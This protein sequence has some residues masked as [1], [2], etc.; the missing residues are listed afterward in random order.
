MY[1][2]DY[3]LSSLEHAGERGQAFL[4]RRRPEKILCNV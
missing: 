1:S 4:G 2:C 3:F